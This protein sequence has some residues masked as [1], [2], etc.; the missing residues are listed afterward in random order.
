MIDLI[1]HSNY[2][3]KNAIAKD[4]KVSWPT[5]KKEMDELIKNGLIVCDNDSPIKKYKPNPNFGYFLSIAVGATETKVALIDFDFQ[6]V[7]FFSICNEIE[8]NEVVSKLRKNVPQKLISDNYLCFKT[9]RTYIKINEMC[10][11]IIET[12]LGV[13]ENSQKELLSVSISLPGVFDKDTHVMIFCPNIPELVNMDVK[14]IVHKNL[15]DELNEKNI[16]FRIFHDTV[17]ATVYEKENLYRVY[18]KEN[19]YKDCPNMAVIYMGS[20]LGAGLIIQRSLV[21]GATGAVGEIG[22][23]NINYKDLKVDPNDEF[24]LDDQSHYKIKEIEDGIEKEKLEDNININEGTCSCGN[25]YC[26]ERLIRIKVFNAKNIDDYLYKTSK[27][28][29]NNFVKNHPYRYEVLKYLIGCVLNITINYINVDLIA[30]TGRIL[31][32][33]PQLKQEMETLK[34]GYSLKTSA[35]KCHIL[36]EPSP[37]DSVAIGAAIMSYYSLFCDF[38]KEETIRW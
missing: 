19:I 27:E 38:S 33:I 34:T 35:R 22:H 36:T 14:T 10:T 1:R 24:A 12:F 3:D 21:L 11:K 23:I 5:L 31:N 4:L 25:K 32:E 9:E 29:L 13:F 8:F 17:A 26:L 37:P 28:E 7:K 6:P 15:I 18:N 20:G 16:P 30:F 2:T